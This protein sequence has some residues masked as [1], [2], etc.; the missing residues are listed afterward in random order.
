[1]SQH[2]RA[3]QCNRETARWLIEFDRMSSFSVAEKLLYWGEPEDI[4]RGERVGNG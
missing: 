2:P 4:N 1:M 3:A